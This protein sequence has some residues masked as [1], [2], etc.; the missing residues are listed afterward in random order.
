VSERLVVD[1]V[2]CDG[3]GLCVELLPELLES[4]DWGYPVARSGETSPEVPSALHAHARR[5]VR[6]CPVLALHLS[7]RRPVT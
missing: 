3:R 6:E 1:W 5:A 2:A 4:D 7:P